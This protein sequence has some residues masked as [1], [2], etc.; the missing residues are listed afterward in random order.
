MI[1]PTHSTL[2]A[3]YDEDVTHIEGDID[4]V[5]DLDIISEELRLKDLQYLIKN[6]V[7]NWI[8]NSTLW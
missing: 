8:I 1:D 6:I 7:R 5:R 2:G 3:F 4:P